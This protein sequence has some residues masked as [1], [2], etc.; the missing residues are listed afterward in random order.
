MYTQKCNTYVA[1]LR[2]FTCPFFWVFL[3]PPIEGIEGFFEGFCQK[4]SSWQKMGVKTVETSHFFLGQ[5][6]FR[7]VLLW[8]STLTQPLD[9]KTGKGDPFFS[10]HPNVWISHLKVH[11]RKKEIETKMPDNRLFLECHAFFLSLLISPRRYDCFIKCSFG[12]R[13]AR[14]L[15]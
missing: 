5:L 8:N 3:P 9:I 6:S 11:E 7:V 1:S 15:D 12:V 13:F 14:G 4:K 2:G 10:D